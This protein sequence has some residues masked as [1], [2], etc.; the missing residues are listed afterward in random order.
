MSAIILLL[1][2]RS[3]EVSD[4][5]HARELAAAVKAIACF[6]ASPPRG[7]SAECHKWEQLLKLA[8]EID[9]TLPADLSEYELRITFNREFQSVELVRL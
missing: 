9:P 4:E 1:P 6:D 8:R 2:E 5:D 3:P 7:A